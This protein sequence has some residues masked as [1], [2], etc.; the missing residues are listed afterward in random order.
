MSWLYLSAAIIF[1]VAG[2]IS[3]KLSQG[4]S[5]LLPSILIFVFYA[6]AF[7]LSTL[8][9]KKID[10]SVAYTIWAGTGTALIAIIGVFYF[11][12]Q[13]SLLKS[14]SIALI[15]MGI[16]GLKISGS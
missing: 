6:I 4:F 11:G 13:L 2:V 8:A 14:V 5:K 9:I 12:E 7:T 10:V 16:I 15:I 1:E 3:M